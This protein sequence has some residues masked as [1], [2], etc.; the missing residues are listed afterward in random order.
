MIAATPSECWVP[1]VWKTVEIRIPSCRWYAEIQ[2][3]QEQT[4]SQ[5]VEILL[6]LLNVNI[7]IVTALNH[8]VFAF[9]AE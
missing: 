4:W 1:V 7:Q 2:D 3:F 6:V 8:T 9:H 5:G